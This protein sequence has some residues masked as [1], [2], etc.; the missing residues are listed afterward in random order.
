LLL[1][2]FLIAGGGL[3]IRHYHIASLPSFF[4]PTL[5]LLVLSTGLL[6]KYLYRVSQAYFVQLYLVTIALKIM[7]YGAYVFMMALKDKQGILSNVVFFLVSYFFFTGL[8]IVFLYRKKT[9]P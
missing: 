4:V 7:V 5:V 3:L 1:C 6:Y 2:A 8:E 9:H